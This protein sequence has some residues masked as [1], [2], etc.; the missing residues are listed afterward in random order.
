MGVKVRFFASLRDRMGQDETTVELD[1]E[2]TVAAIWQQATGEAEI[3]PN[4]LAALNMD[5]VKA[6]APVADGDE[7]AFFPPVTGG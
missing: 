2:M 4:I 1:G 3:P 7:V 6:D 5:Y